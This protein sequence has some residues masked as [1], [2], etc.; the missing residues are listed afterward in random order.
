MGKA[1]HRILAV[2][3]GKRSGWAIVGQD[4]VVNSGALEITIATTAH[5]LVRSYYSRCTSGPPVVVIEDQHPATMSWRTIKPL[6]YHRH[7]WQIGAELVGCE[8]HVVNPRTWQA[9]F[10][11]LGKPATEEEKVL[12]AYIR[13]EPNRKDPQRKAMVKERGILQR[14]RKAEHKQAI[15]DL[16][17]R[18]AGRPCEPDE[19]DAVLIGT[20]WWRAVER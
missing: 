12:T 2:D 19:A 14:A 9:H 11:I 16:A 8:Q 10:C 15:I 6:L 4:G 3:P 18:T 17:S 5:A 13:S 7:C 1:H 20:W